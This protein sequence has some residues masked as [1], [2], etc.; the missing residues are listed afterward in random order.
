MADYPLRPVIDTVI[1]TYPEL[2]SKADLIHSVFAAESTKWEQAVGRGKQ[3]L[4]RLVRRRS[5]EGKEVSAADVAWLWHTHGVAVE[6]ALMVLGDASIPLADVEAEV[7]KHKASG[8][9]RP[10]SQRG[11]ERD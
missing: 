4:S 7:A 9:R 1:E 5:K 3:E 6:M 8:G 2:R 11:Q 10:F